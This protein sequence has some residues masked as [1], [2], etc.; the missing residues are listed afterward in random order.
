M[1]NEIEMEQENV[2]LAAA[3][4]PLLFALQNLMKLVWFGFDFF[5]RTATKHLSGQKYQHLAS[6]VCFLNESHS[7]L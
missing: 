5:Y 3:H 1:L 7:F 4:L 6:F 2:R